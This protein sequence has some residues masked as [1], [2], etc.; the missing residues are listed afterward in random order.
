M[1]HLADGEGLYLC[2]GRAEARARQEQEVQ[3]TMYFVLDD[4]Y[5]F[6]SQGLFS[7]LWDNKRY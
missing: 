6:L 1:V 7:N 3:V 2:G 5:I 4:F